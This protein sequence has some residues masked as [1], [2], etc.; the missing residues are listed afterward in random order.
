MA[1]APIPGGTKTRLQPLLGPEGCARLQA[2]LIRRAA[3]LD[4]GHG[5]LAHTPPEAG[6]LLRPLVG[7]QLTLFPQEGPNLG[8][9][10]AAAAAARLAQG[11]DVVLGP[12]YDGGYYLIALARPDP[13]VFALPASVWGCPDVTA[14]TID[15]AGV[16][17][18]RLGFID[19]E[20]DL[21]TPADAAT[22]LTDPRL[23]PELAALLRPGSHD[24]GQA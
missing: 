17:G 6:A 15:A 7:P 18:L 4:A 8:A 22:L 19:P 2:A 16:A 9:R 11:C 14:Y 12:A 21:D 24:Y 23:P 3:A 5:F 1:R 13:R 20:H 10:M